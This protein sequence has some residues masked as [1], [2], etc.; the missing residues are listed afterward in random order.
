MVFVRKIEIFFHE[1]EKY[2]L[3]SVSTVCVLRQEF[4]TP[5]AT[6][7]A[8]HLFAYKPMGYDEKWTCTTEVALFLMI[9]KLVQSSPL[10][11]QLFLR[12]FLKKQ[13]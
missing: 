1:K 2:L 7:I 11:H 13:A 5:V 3:C 12:F 4:I 6:M 8:E 9:T 10:L